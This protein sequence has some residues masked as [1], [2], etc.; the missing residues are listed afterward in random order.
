QVDAGSRVWPQSHA[1]P[2]RP[3][4]PG[5]AP[6]SRSGPG[7]AVLERCGRPAD[8]RHPGEYRAGWLALCHAPG[9]ADSGGDGGPGWHRLRPAAVARAGEGALRPDA[10]TA[11]TIALAR[12]DVMAQLKFRKT[13]LDRLSS[14]EQLDRLLQVT[15]PRGWIAL[16]GLGLLLAASLLWGIF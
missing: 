1:L 3:G 8:G 11:D 4:Q 16:V 7:G 2:R 10:G 12:E 13:A 5:T 6:R 15:S 14:S 9:G